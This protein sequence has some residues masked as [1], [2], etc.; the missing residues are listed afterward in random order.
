MRIP[1]GCYKR[2]RG[3]HGNPMWFNSWIFSLLSSPLS[4]KVG[5]KWMLGEKLLVMLVQ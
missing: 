2:F 4:S 5:I 3:F 1:C